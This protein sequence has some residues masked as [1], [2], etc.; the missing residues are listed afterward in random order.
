MRHFSETG[1]SGM[2]WN[3]LTYILRAFYI[4][5][6]PLA[7]ALPGLDELLL[8]G[9]VAERLEAARAASGAAAV[10]EAAGASGVPET[11]A[12]AVVPDVAEAACEPRGVRLR[13]VNE[14]QV[15]YSSSGA[16]ATRGSA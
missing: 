5:Y 6:R 10:A 14:W 8:T 12:A 15:Q 1:P 4:P 11:A 13:S 7:E 9:C 3:G 16:T 2:F